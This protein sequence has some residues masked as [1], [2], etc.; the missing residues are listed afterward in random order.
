[1][2]RRNI[3]DLP[4]P[5][6][7]FRIDKDTRRQDGQIKFE[8]PG[9]CRRQ[10]KIRAKGLRRSIKE[11]TDVIDVRHALKLAE[12]LE[13][14]AETGEYPESPASSLYMGNQRRRIVGALWQLVEL[15]S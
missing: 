2:S 4:L 11:S 8:K 10:D 13:R 9:F 3:G 1:M 12:Q 7:G 15:G 6:K 5:P 14:S